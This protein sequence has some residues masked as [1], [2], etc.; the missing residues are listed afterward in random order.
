[1]KKLVARFWLQAAGAVVGAIGGFLYWK[2]VGCT[3]G[4]C[5]ITSKP[6]NST[7]YFAVIGALLFSM[8]QKKATSTP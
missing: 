2:F 5:P 6:F 7:L 8:F 4:S 3:S 1:M